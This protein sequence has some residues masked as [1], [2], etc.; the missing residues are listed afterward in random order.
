MIEELNDDTKQNCPEEPLLLANNQESSVP[1]ENPK[2]VS[3]IITADSIET[4]AD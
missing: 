4:N 1:E 3:N 2:E